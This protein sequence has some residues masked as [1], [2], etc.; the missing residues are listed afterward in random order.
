MMTGDKIRVARAMKRITQEQLA[1]KAGISR[2]TLRKIENGQ[3][4][5]MSI[6]TAMSIA[7]A[8]GLPLEFLLYD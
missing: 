7:D 1:E 4:K 2:V 5:N 6:K 8:L 3:T